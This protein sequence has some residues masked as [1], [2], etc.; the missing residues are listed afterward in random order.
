MGAIQNFRVSF[1]LISFD[2]GLWKG[3]EPRESQTSCSQLHRHITKDDETGEI[4]SDTF[5][6]VGQKKYC[7]DC[8]KELKPADIISGYEYEKGK[9]VEITPADKE[10]IKVERSSKITIDQMVPRKYILERLE[11][12]DEY[13]KLRPVESGAKAQDLEAFAT[14]LEAIGDQVLIGHCAMYSRTRPLAI[15]AGKGEFKVFTLMYDGEI[16]V[17]QN[18]A[19]PEVPKSYIKMAK[20]VLE[21]FKTDEPM[22]DYPDDYKEGFVAMVA[23]KV[24][25]VKKDETVEEPAPVIKV[26]STEDMFKAA[27]AEIESGK[28]KKPAPRK[29][30]S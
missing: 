27:L 29:K 14:M 9:F 18:N 30:A 10:A 12:L 25:G 17:S 16:R 2:A 4:T 3:T 8:K 7:K 15:M 28:K 11:I 22:L 13:Y 1:N 5:H 24:K 26:G 20:Q 6:P 21:T 23:D 19:L